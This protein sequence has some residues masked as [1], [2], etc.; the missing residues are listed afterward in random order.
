VFGG[1]ELMLIPLQAPPF[2]CRVCGAPKL[3]TNHWLFAIVKPGFEGILFQPIEA[4]DPDR[5]PLF[6]YEEICGQGCCHTRLSRYLDDLNETFKAIQKSEA[7]H[8][9]E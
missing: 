2:I 6:T 4:T 1:D 8:D 5:N 3:N 9:S 7:D